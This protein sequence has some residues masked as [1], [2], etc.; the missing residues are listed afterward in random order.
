QGLEIEE[1]PFPD[2]AT[3]TPQMAGVGQGRPVLMTEKDAVKCSGGGW[4]DA[5]YLTVDAEVEP[6]AAA[7]LLDRIAR[8]P[9]ARH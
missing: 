4:Q 6:A 5:W 8:L 2:H 3:I 9:T 1:R 7:I